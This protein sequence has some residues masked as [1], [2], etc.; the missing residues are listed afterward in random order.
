[1]YILHIPV[2][3]ELSIAISKTI[4]VS[5][6]ADMGG[7]IYSAIPASFSFSIT[8]TNFTNNSARRVGGV[9]WGQLGSLYIEGSRFTSNTAQQ[10]GGIAFAFNSSICIA[11][12]EFSH[13]SGSLYTFN[14]NLTISGYTIFKNST[15]ILNMQES[16]KVMYFKKEGQSLAFDQ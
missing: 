2:S 4:F 12:C 11:E 9:F 6:G 15:Q 8:A 16:C 7:V 1:M 3:D 13:N 14:G 5:N 10:N